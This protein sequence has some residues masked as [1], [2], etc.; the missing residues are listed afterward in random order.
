MVVN[1]STANNVILVWWFAVKKE[2]RLIFRTVEN[3]NGKF[4]SSVIAGMKKVE[5]VTQGRLDAIKA[6]GGER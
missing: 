3:D 5:A 6:F 2:G 4:I 1:Q